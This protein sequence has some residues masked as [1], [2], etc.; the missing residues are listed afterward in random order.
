MASSLLSVTIGRLLTPQVSASSL[1]VKEDGDGRRIVR[2][3]DVVRELNRRFP[4]HEQNGLYFTIVYGVLDVET[5]EFRYALAGHPQIVHSPHNSSPC[6]LDAEGMAIGWT[7]N[8]DC[9]EKSIRL[10][11]GDRLWLYS[12]GVPE[13][14][15]PD[16]R[17]F[18]N[19]QL[20]EVIEIGRRGSLDESTNLLMH[21]VERWGRDGS[22]RD[23][24][25][26]LALEIV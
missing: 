17:Q 19:S 20:L 21:A 24:V 16:K 11:Q 2:P 12:D 4:M 14:M 10:S 13:A 6:F 1:L 18:G 8:L 7:P 5:L 22:L 25:S 15:D 26:I 23:D 9:D 3:L